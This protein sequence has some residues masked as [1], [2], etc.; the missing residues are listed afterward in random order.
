MGG[1]ASSDALLSKR[2]CYKKSTCFFYSASPT[3]NRHL[4]RANRADLPTSRR[5]VGSRITHAQTET[6]SKVEHTKSGHIHSF[7][8]DQHSQAATLLL[9]STQPLIP[10]RDT[11]RHT[12]ARH[13]NKCFF[14]CWGWLFGRQE[15][16]TS[17]ADRIWVDR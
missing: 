17:Y 12:T 10:Q 9:T 3:N 4:V 11:A 7:S 15:A 1:A 16:S 14:C 5:L 13:T 2:M 6:Q 8:H